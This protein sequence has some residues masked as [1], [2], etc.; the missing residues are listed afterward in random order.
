MRQNFF[1]ICAVIKSCLDLLDE[2]N[3]GNFS[4]IKGRAENTIP[5]EC[6]SPLL[7][8]FETTKRYA[9]AS[10][11]CSAPHIL[12]SPCFYTSNS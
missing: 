5:A 2:I 7:N 10:L 9:V 1:C 12:A 3:G 11:Q 8:W 4:A 6:N